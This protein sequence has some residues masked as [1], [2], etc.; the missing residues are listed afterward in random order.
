LLSIDVGRIFHYYL[1]IF[2][3]SSFLFHNF[4]RGFGMGGSRF[5]EVDKTESSWAA[6]PYLNLSF[7]SRGG[8]T[9]CSNPSQLYRISKLKIVA[10]ILPVLVL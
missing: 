3:H 6:K 10:S 2:E 1:T 7:F 9:L 4:L 8:S 5:L